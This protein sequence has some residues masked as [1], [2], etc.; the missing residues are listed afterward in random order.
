[1]TDPRTVADPLRQLAELTTAMH[2]GRDA[3][4]HRLDELGG[5]FP[6]AGQ[7]SPGNAANGG[8]T[9]AAVIAA[10]DDHRTDIA[11]IERKG[12]ERDQRKALE[13]VGAMWAR[14]QRIVNVR[15]GVAMMTDPGCDLCAKV[16]CGDPKCRCSALDGRHYCETF[17]TVTVVEPSKRKGQPDTERKVKLCVSCHD[18]NRERCAGRLPTHDEVLDHVEGR[19]RRWKSA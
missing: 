12:W 18:F 15:M 9:L 14:Y 10:V 5:G 8:P 1:M 6:S 2:H 16:P 3:F 4:E 19:K 11:D 13:H 7:G 17:A